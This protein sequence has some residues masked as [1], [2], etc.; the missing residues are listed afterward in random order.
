[1]TRHQSDILRLG[2]CYH[3]QEEQRQ[4]WQRNQRP[5]FL[6]GMADL[7]RQRLNRIIFYLSCNK[8]KNKSE[9]FTV[10]DEQYVALWSMFGRFRAG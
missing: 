8:S 7:L 10:L 6:H 1:M 5:L 3:R 2:A 9:I 4:A